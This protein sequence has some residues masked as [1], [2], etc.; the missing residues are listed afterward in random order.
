MQ[1]YNHDNQ[2]HNQQVLYFIIYIVS[3]GTFAEKWKRVW[4]TIYKDSG[5]FFF[6]KKG[7]PT[8]KFNIRLQVRNK[9]IHWTGIGIGSTCENFLMY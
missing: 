4:V 8:S 3:E 9:L 2:H 6:K 1:Y 7:D 5:M